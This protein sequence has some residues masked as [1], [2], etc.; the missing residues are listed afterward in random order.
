MHSIFKIYR[1]LLLTHLEGAH[2]RPIFT[3]KLMNGP[4]IVVKILEGEFEQQMKL[5]SS[6]K[7][8]NVVKSTSPTVPQF[9]RVAVYDA[10][11]VRTLV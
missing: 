10:P 8:E 6:I 9:M 5:L 4:K 7:H 1:V 3:A 2:F 11:E